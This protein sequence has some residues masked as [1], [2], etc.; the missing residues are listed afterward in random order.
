MLWNNILEFQD[1]RKTPVAEYLDH[2][3]G[4]LAVHVLHLSITASFT[5]YFEIGIQLFFMEIFVTIRTVDFSFTPL[6][7]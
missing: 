7:T 2:K 3:V 1:Y 4:T 5:F 6:I